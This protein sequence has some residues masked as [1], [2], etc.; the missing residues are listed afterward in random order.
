[1]NELYIEI[2]VGELNDFCSSL[3]DGNL[4]FLSSYSV[5]RLD[6]EKPDLL[7]GLTAPFLF[8]FGETLPCYCIPG[9]IKLFV[10]SNLEL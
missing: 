6:G 8:L 7:L 9:A 4:A 10:S 3:P 2:D 5:G 1:M